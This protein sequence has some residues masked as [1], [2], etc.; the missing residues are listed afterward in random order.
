MPGHLEPVRSP[1]EA[2]ELITD[3][4][5]AAAVPVARAATQAITLRP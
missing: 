4:L 3:D 2:G 1:D 5:L